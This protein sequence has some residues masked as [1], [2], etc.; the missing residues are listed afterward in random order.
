MLTSNIGPGDFMI[1]YFK[2]RSE[3]RN[4]HWLAVDDSDGYFLPP[5]KSR[6]KEE[7]LTHNIFRA[8]H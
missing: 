2:R 3:P 6:E 5:K 7:E 1:A 4:P 8:E